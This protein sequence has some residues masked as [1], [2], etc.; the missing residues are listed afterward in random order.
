MSDP[1]YRD[2][3]RAAPQFLKDLHKRYQKLTVLELDNEPDLLDLRN[4]EHARRCCGLRSVKSLPRSE[5]I[6]ASKN[7]HQ[8]KETAVACLPDVE[9]F[10]SAA[11]PG[12]P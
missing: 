10:E 8:C 5:I 9:V 3:H 2:P 7:L 6:E 11:V 12:K 4:I 1:G